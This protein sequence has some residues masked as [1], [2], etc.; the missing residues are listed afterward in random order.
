M[1]LAG[2][3]AL[4]SLSAAWEPAHTGEYNQRM[5]GGRK[6]EETEGEEERGEGVG[7]E[8]ERGRERRE[9]QPFESL[10]F[11]LNQGLK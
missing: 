2:R 6:T 11:L 10:M 5:A 1:G 8:G 3:R 4:G 9:S 7:G